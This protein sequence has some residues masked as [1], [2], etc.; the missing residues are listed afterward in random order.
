M[1]SS[2]CTLQAIKRRRQSLFLVRVR[3]SGA[4]DL[5]SDFGHR[6]SGILLTLAS[7]FISRFLLSLRQVAQ[8][9]HFSACEIQGSSA[10]IPTRRKWHTRSEWSWTSLYFPGSLQRS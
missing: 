4:S 3:S 7:M 1:S 5:A 9:Y 6:I 2:S 8:T 10:V